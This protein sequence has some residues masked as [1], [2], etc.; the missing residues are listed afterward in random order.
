MDRECKQD[1]PPAAVSPALLE[2]E[3]E[4]LLDR[5]DDPLSPDM[6]PIAD[7]VP[8]LTGFSH[9]RAVL[10]NRNF[11]LLWSGQVFSQLADKV[12]LV[13][14][15]SLI[16]S[17]FQAA[18]QSISRWVAAVMVASTL[19]AIFFG[20][21]AGVYVDRWSKKGVMVIS[22]LLRGCLVLGIP[23][24]LW[25]AQGQEIWGG[26]PMGFV[27]LLVI[28]FSVSTLTQYFAPAEQSAIPLV[29]A[30][31]QLL[32]ANSLYTTTMMGS[33]ILGFAIG[34]PLLA[35]ADHLLRRFWPTAD[36]G[37]T[38][39]VGGAYIV[40]AAILLGLHTQEADRGSQE[41]HLW[42][43]IQAGLTYLQA[44]PVVRSAMIQII[45]L[46][47]VFAAVAVLAVR[48]AELI[49]GLKATQF[50]FLLAA[51]GV[52]MGMGAFWVGHSGHSMSRRHWSLWGSLGI[53][54]LLALLPEAILSL[55]S[56]LIVIAGVGLAGSWV[57]IP[58][59][60]VIQEETPADLRGK[61]FG[62]QNNLANIALSLPLV[63]A[64]V[65]ETYYG[66]PPVLWGLSGIVG[67]AGLL[68]WQMTQPLRR[69]PAA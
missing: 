41:F 17:H 18:G 3:P 63:L 24:L 38:L 39:V 13:L 10:A 40:A 68:T 5:A 25:M 51:A 14:M 45:T 34:D 12:L 54:V 50:G 56:T 53:A 66:L 37:A 11:L 21:L 48:M 62:L 8:A 52:G 57:V 64:G 35:L 22:N 67:L 23:L 30:K 47:S 61:V 15:I 55:P 2:R 32:S 65:A 44:T 58:M 26:I 46:Y 16:S 9:Y 1:A 42:Q 36:F 4:Q 19:P 49:P 27:E 7:P 6:Q 60:T 33:V 20:T 31:P 28:T 43:D 29:V 59:Q 69:D